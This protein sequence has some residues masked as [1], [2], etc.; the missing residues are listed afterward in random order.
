MEKTLEMDD[1]KLLNTIEAASA[2]NIAPQTLT[3]WRKKG[4]GPDF[5]KNGNIYYYPVKKLREF[6]EYRTEYLNQTQGE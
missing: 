3:N 6:I 2:L 4:L 5:I 1:L